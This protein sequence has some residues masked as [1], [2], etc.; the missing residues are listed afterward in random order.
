MRVFLIAVALLATGCGRSIAAPDM[1]PLVV[2]VIVS[3]A[4]IPRGQTIAVTVSITNRASQPESYVEDWCAA[5]AVMNAAG[6]VVGPE[7][8]CFSVQSLASVTLAPGEQR[9]YTAQ[10]ATDSTI[11]AGE[12]T[13]AGALHGDNVENIPVTIQIAH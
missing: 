6:S 5:F 8:G 7:S 3:P 4:T 13:I 2:S 1:M 10:W 11:Q 12:Y 9:L